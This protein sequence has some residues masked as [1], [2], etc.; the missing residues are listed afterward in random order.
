[1]VAVARLTRCVLLL[2]CCLL[3]G[4]AG[5]AVEYAESFWHGNYL[6]P[7]AGCR[8][9]YPNTS[10]QTFTRVVLR[11]TKP[12][13]VAD[14]YRYST[15]T[16]TESLSGSIN[17]N[18]P[19]GGYV[20]NTTTQ[21][22]ERTV[23]TC[24]PPAVLNTATNVC[25]QPTCPAAG[26]PLGDPGQSVWETTALTTSVCMGGCS[27]SGVAAGSSGGTNYVWG[28]F[29][30]GG[31]T[32]APSVSAPAP[33]TPASGAPA[34]SPL[35][36]GTCPGTVN[37]TAVVVPCSSS[38]A[39][40][41]TTTTGAAVTASAPNSGAGAVGTSTTTGSTSCT[42][43][44]CTTTSTT[45]TI[46]TSGSTTTTP[47]TTTQ[48]IESFCALNPGNAICRGADLGPGN[49]GEEGEDEEGD[50][51][52][53]GGTCAATTCSGDA[54][55]CA[56]AQEQA[57]RNCELMD[58]PTPL[59]EIGEAAANGQNPANHPKEGIETQVIALSSMISTVPLFGSSGQCPTNQT[60]TVQ[61]QVISLPFGT[62]CPYLQ[63]LGAAFMAACYLAAA[64]IVFKRS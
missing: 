36:P 60:V 46:G 5:A 13:R 48:P 7:D 27:G 11:G 20:A 3:A 62:M 23:A 40:S 10:T 57:R 18:C 29:T 52:S 6:T 16:S 22:C 45:T 34:P 44:I 53:F 2:A 35:E 63:M 25:D 49:E 38:V 15:Q 9:G 31:G 26:Q 64:F 24:T 51:R 14:C 41:A 43:G 39:P 28:P 54:I 42:G 30:S 58:T 19:S 50:D 17:E 47:T 12:T 1:M 21:R 8:A 33:S 37:G 55:Q 59:S 32:C 56:I 4:T 61:G